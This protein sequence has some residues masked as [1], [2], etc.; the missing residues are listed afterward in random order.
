[1]NTPAPP[2]T[3]GPESTPRSVVVRMYRQMLGDCFLLI[4]EGEDAE[5]RRHILIDC[6]ILQGT[7]EAGIRM[8]KV[9]DNLYDSCG[10]QLDLVIVTHEHWDHISGFQF[11]REQF[12]K[13][14]FDRL[15]LAWTEDPADP[16]GTALRERFDATRKKLAALAMATGMRL[17]D[18]A[19]HQGLLG[20]VGP[21]A[22]SAN[23]S[24]P[25]RGSRAIYQNLLRWTKQ[26]PQYLSPG[27]VE[28][29]PGGLKAYVLAPPRDEK[30]LFK[31][32]PGRAEAGETYLGATATEAEL[33]TAQKQSPF[34]PRYR[35]RGYREIQQA[36]NRQEVSRE[37]YWLHE[38]YF[39]SSADPDQG[40]EWPHR[41]IDDSHSLD[42]NRLAI[43]MDNKTNNSSL[44]VA[45][46]LPDRSTLIFAADAQ[47]GNWMSWKDVTFIE[48]HADG[49]EHQIKGQDLLARACFYKVGHHGSHNATLSKDGLERM[50]R[51]DLVA[52]I[53]TDAK[54]ALKQ[55]KGWLMPNPRVDKALHKQASGR[56]LRGDRRVDEVIG[57]LNAPLREGFST[58]TYE[59][60]DG[61]YIEYLA[62]GNWPAGHPKHRQ[63]PTR[64]AMDARRPRG[65]EGTEERP[66]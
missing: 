49:S 12:D 45:F 64:G 56:V 43:R 21:L 6:G 51:D 31:A 10:Q 41:Q 35:W 48:R 50:V 11:G 30:L 9:V 3:I 54:F 24:D 19:E 29:A 17:D 28:T 18:E 22:A 14:G 38:R 42:F 32:L 40:W 59:E 4:I 13:H 39:K 63:T 25:P 47:V 52:M 15:W 66:T 34:S 57:E 58:R 23:G 20:F 26:P 60:P 53:P 44:V 65:A 62:F 55:G 1:M 2:A 46:E 27:T 37:E 36:S 33:E 16:Q 61:L 7:P 5:Q 8:R